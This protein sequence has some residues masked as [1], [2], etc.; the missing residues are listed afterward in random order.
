MK[1]ICFGDSLTRGITLDKGRL[2]ITKKNYPNYLKEFLNRNIT[3]I[4]KGVFNDNSDLLLKRLKKDVLEEN[5]DFVIIGIG[6]N[7]CNFDWNEVAEHPDSEHQAIVPADRYIANVRTMTERMKEAGITPIVM[8]LPPLD[9]VRYYQFLFKQYG[10]SIG[11]WISLKG[12][13]EHWHGMYNDRLMN[14]ADEM[15]VG[16][17]DVRT[18]LR[19][20][21]SLQDLISDDGIHLTSAGYRVVGREISCFFNGGEK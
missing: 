9:P 18:A 11:H 15:Q 21:G 7:D 5:P 8:T 6:G 17:A 2:R 14:L 19:Q 1:I 20:A 16:K 10:S 12:G 3:V 13:M 4:N